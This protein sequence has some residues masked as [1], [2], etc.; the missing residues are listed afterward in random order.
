MFVTP[1]SPLEVSA[2]EVESFSWDEQTS[3][4]TAQDFVRHD[5]HDHTA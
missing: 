4:G 3:E 1:R 2:F 5:Y